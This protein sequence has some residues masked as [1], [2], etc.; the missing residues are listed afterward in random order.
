[1]EKQ[2][3]T[4]SIIMFIV[5]LLLCVTVPFGVTKYALPYFDSDTNQSQSVPQDLYDQTRI[6]QIC[7]LATLKCFYHNVAEYEKQPDALFQYGLFKYGYKKM[8]IEYSG[9]VEVGVNASD[10]R[11][12]NADEN[13]VVSIY[14]P[15]AVVL[16]VTADR[17]SLSA[18]LME[19]GLFTSIDAQDKATAFAEAQKEMEEE[20]GQDTA[21][22]SQA[23]ENAKE[24]IRQYVLNIGKLTNN[25]YQIKWIT[26][27]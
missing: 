11:I 26:E 4:F 22:L 24:L 25:E 27:T 12:S 10:I 17:N 9:I 3:N 7:E 21:I 6:S 20:A 15:D 16:N 8:W 5:G 13:N 18:P 2:T 14:I 23:K 19:T 1:M